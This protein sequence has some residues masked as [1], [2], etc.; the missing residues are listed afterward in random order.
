MIGDQIQFFILRWWAYFISK[1]IN[2]VSSKS[3]MIELSVQ[4]LAQNVK[5][6]KQFVK[7]R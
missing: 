4:K 6:Y 3:G 2:Y 7:L 5:N 1:L